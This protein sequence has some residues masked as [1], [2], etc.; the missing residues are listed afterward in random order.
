MIAND[1]ELELARQNLANVEAAIESLCKELLPGHERNFRLYAQPWLDFKQQFESE[2][3]AYL[4]KQGSLRN[5]AS[6][7]PDVAD[8]QDLKLT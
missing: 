5:G 4:T 8:V 7:R 6:P 2:I 3:E 1:A